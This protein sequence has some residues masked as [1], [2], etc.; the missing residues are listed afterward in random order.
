MHSLKRILRKETFN[1]LTCHSAA[2]TF[3]LMALH[4]VQVIV[5]DQRMP[6]MNGTEFFN[7]VKDMYPDT[8]RLVLS[9]YTGLRSV[10][11]AINHGSIHKFITKPWQDDFLEKK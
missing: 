1:I 3:D 7:R 4:N 10:T 2:E 8:I 9:G 11:D 6:K 5:S